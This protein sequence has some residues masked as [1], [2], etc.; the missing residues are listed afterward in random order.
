MLLTGIGIH[1]ILSIMFSNNQ[2]LDYISLI[3]KFTNRHIFNKI[4]LIRIN[5]IDCQSF[6]HPHIPEIIFFLSSRTMRCLFYV[7]VEDVFKH[8]KLRNIFY[9]K[10]KIGVIFQLFSLDYLNSNIVWLFQ[11]FSTL[12]TQKVTLTSSIFLMLAPLSLGRQIYPRLGYIAYV[13]YQDCHD[14]LFKR[15]SYQAIYLFAKIF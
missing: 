12:F 13:F 6:I 11:N 4:F 9:F 3:S 1:S 8:Q 14:Y 2:F 10:R 15:N 5:L 7:M